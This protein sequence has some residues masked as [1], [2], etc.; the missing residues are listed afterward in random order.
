MSNKVGL[1][2]TT[3]Q[4]GETFTAVA[5]YHRQMTAQRLGASCMALGVVGVVIAL[6]L[7]GCQANP[8]RFAAPQAKAEAA[9]WMQQVTK[10]ITKS[11]D[12]VKTSLRSN[13]AIACASDHS[14]FATKF[15][16]RNFTTVVAK[17]ST[18]AALSL[19]EQALTQAGWTSRGAHPIVTGRMLTLTSPRVSGGSGTVTVETASGS[20]ELTIAAVSACYDG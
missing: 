10:S 6:A 20:P 11:I 18:D 7:A 16:W 17:G 4:C 14:Y 19:I 13:A 2:E 8:N 15:A 3:R 9:G 12:P 5:A 1:T